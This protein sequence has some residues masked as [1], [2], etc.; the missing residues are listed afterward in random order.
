M[1]HTLQTQILADG[2][3]KTIIKV[4]L[5]SDGSSGELTNQI[6]FDASSYVTQSTD[7]SLLRVTYNLNGFSGQLKWAGNG[8]TPV[9]FS[10]TGLNDMTSGGTYTGLSDTTYIVEID[11]TGTPDTFKW[12]DDNGASYT[13]GVAITGGAQVL[14]N[15]VSVTFAATT[16]HTLADSWTFNAN[17]D[18][19]IVTLDQDI[20]EDVDYWSV[21]GGIYNNAAAATRT[22]DILITTN[23]FG[24]AGDIGYIVLYVKQKS[25][26]ITR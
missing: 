18:I 19:T 16:G 5:I 24:D 11:A 14:S 4:A 2:K 20:A 6:I 25:V 21:A 22:G 3:S 1:A 8:L 10:G 13:T 17:A 7:N 26:S 9:V 23:G 12:S 15:G